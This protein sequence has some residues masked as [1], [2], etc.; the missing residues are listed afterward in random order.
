[1]QVE[2]RQHLADLGGLAA[3]RRQVGDP[4]A[5]P[6]PVP[7]GITEGKKF[8]TPWISYEALAT[9]HD[10]VEL[11]RA[12]SA[13]GTRRRPPR[14]WGELL[15]VTEP[16]CR[17]GLL[18]G[19]RRPWASLPPADRRRLVVPDGGWCLLAVKKGGG[20]FTAWATDFER[21]SDRTQ[22]CFEPRFPGVW[23]HQ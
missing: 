12:A 10:Y 23:P 7:A 6:V 8:R 15:M 3:P 21:T 17:G 4:R 20:P 16:G 9:V 1:M 11:D 14:R 22:A 5:G 13:E 2:Q 18:H 19:I